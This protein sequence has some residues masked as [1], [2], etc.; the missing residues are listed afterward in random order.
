MVQKGVYSGSENTRF[1]D[2][3]EFRLDGLDY[4]PDLLVVVVNIPGVV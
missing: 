1:K 4:V 2:P 3:E